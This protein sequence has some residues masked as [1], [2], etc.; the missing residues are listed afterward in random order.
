MDLTGKVVVLTGASSGIGRKTA[1]DLAGDGAKVCLIARREGLLRT[2]ADELGGEAAGHS[3]FVA[4][5]SDIDQVKGA[6][7]HVERTYGRC[8]VLINN[9]GFSR[10]GYFEGLGS[11]DAVRACIE[12]NYLG[13][14]NCVAA[15]LE[16]L[17]KSAPAR[18]VNVASMAGRLTFPRSSAYVASKFALVGWSESVRFD[19]EPRGIT[20]SLI[21]PGPIPTEG[22]PQETLVGH[23]VLRYA[24]GTQAGV[25]SA[26]RRSAGGGKAQRVIPRWYYLLQFPRVVAPPLY[27]FLAKR[28]ATPHVVERD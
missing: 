16:L 1:V 12:T 13:A 5:V 11:L 15:F 6:A 23:P 28:L 4:D 8:D 10:G 14:V 2:L 17:E 20:V 9:A 19:L 22:F 3:Y 24:L 7:A 21:E 26:I 18:I 25:S 27:R